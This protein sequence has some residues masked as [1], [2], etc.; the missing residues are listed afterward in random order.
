MNG[1]VRGGERGSRSLGTV[2]PVKTQ[3]EQN[4]RGYN[5][6]SALGKNCQSESCHLL[7]DEG[8]AGGGSEL[9]PCSPHPSTAEKS[10]ELLYNQAKTYM[11]KKKKEKTSY[12]SNEGPREKGDSKTWEKILGEETQSKLKSKLAEMGMRRKSFVPQSGRSCRTTWAM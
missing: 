8:Q 5:G 11:G 1:A 12:V 4:A 10:F 3:P 6:R 7:W 9:V 2:W